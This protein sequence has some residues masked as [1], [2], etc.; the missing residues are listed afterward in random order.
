MDNTRDGQ[1]AR[2]YAPGDEAKI[3]DL[4]D[5]VLKWPAFEPEVPRSD[6]WRWKYVD[7][8]G[9]P[10]HIGLVEDNGSIVCHSG[11]LPLKI[12]IGGTE[13]RCAEGVDVCG[14]PERSDRDMVLRAILCKNEQIE[15]RGTE[16]TFSF[17]IE[18]MYDTLVGQFNYRDLGVRT[19]W[20]LCV[21]RPEVF[22]GRSSAG[23]IKRGLYDAVRLRAMG[24]GHSVGD[25]GPGTDTEV[26]QR[27]GPE[28]SDFFDEVS[29]N[30]DIIVKRDHKYLNWRYADRRAGSFTILIA[31]KGREVHGYLVLKMEGRGESR[32]GHIADLLVRPESSE[33]ADRLLREALRHAKE[34]GA[35]SL[36]CRLLYGHPY[37]GPLKRVGFIRLR[38]TPADR[39][40]R[41]TLCNRYNL[42]EIDRV[43]SKKDLKIHMML[44]D[45]DMV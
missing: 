42:P 27:F 38:Q 14:D 6:F 21:I 16:V 29:S 28:A 15:R 7:V 5:K 1:A 11:G 10:A 39:K 26:A 32:I 25:G 12:L 13:Y 41:L 34:G 43:L 24:G 35:V 8:P 36:Y 4:L 17:P 9:G 45:T 44:G 40:T 2:P 37:S 20:F 31:R 19:A 30:F 33:V 22:F 3:I 23:A 18:S